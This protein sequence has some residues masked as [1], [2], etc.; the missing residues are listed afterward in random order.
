MDLR[1]IK[2]TILYKLKEL[3]KYRIRLCKCNCSCKKD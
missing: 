1:L 3:L 2:E